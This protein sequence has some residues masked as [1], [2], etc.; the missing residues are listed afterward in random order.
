MK[1]G[2]SDIYPP[3]L[4]WWLSQYTGHSIGRTKVAASFVENF[5]LTVQ[6]VPSVKPCSI[7]VA[8]PPSTVD[9]TQ[10]VALIQKTWFG[11]RNHC[12]ERTTQYAFVPALLI[13]QYQLWKQIE[14]EARRRKL[15]KWEVL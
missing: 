15:P 14:R 1:T 13:G 2:V 3:P 8:P 7:S 4:H 5:N 6:R 10:R 12:A 9:E 11:H